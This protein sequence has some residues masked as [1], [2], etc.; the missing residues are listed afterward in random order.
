MLES[1]KVN[2]QAKDIKLKNVDEQGSMLVMPLSHSFVFCGKDLDPPH[3]L[4]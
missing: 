3:H 1:L 4:F 2:S